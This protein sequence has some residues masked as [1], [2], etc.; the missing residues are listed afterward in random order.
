MTKLKFVEQKDESGLRLDLGCGKGANKPDGF[1]GVD[2]VKSKAVDKVADLRKK[3][4]WKTGTI[5]EINAHYLL[6]YFTP[7][8]RIHFVNE[9][10]RVLV[11]GGKLVIASPHWCA[12]KA[13]ADLQ[14]H[15]PPVSEA[16]FT[17]LNKAFREAQNYDLPGY[18][19]DF[20]YTLGYGLH[21]MIVS[22]NLEYQQNAVNY[23]KEAAQDIFCTL[24][25]R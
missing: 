20:D 15:W 23:W 25:K 11:P 21:P 12:S 22:R 19:C 18:A 10:F 4:P 17:C 14:V 24:I 16:W 6:Q 5:L 13:Y 8:E 7:A 1:L 9:A 3:W 2:I